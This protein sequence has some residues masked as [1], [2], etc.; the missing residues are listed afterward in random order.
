MLDLFPLLVVISERQGIIIRINS[1]PPRQ[2]LHKHMGSLLSWQFSLA[3]RVYMLDGNGSVCFIEG[4]RISNTISYV[5]HAAF[6]NLAMGL[7]Q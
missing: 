6:T 5:R 4:G 3:S 2:S 7:T 1:P